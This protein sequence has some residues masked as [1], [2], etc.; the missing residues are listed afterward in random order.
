[1]YNRIMN[2]CSYILDQGPVL[3]D[4]DTIGIDANA[5][6]RIRQG[7][8]SNGGSLLSLHPIRA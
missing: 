2:L 3:N 7:H 8:D 4:G 1:M 6:M 5:S